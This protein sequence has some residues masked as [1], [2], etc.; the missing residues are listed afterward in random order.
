MYAIEALLE[1]FLTPVQPAEEYPQPSMPDACAEVL[2]SDGRYLVL[3][4]GRGAG[5]SWSVARQLLWEGT[6]FPIRV[7]C[8]REF[9]KSI[10]DSVH[11]LLSDMIEELGY[12]AH[13]RVLEHEIRG[14]NGTVFWFAGLHHNVKNIKSKEGIDV[15]WIEEA[16]T[17]SADSL[18]K[19]LPT[20]RKVGSRIILTFNP[21]QETDAVYLMFVED[22]TN[23]QWELPP[24]TVRKK[25]GWQDNPYISQEL[26]DLKDFAY[27]VD[28]VAAEH[29]WGGKCRTE[30]E[31]QILRG[32]WSW[33]WFE[34]EPGWRGPYYGLDFG[35]SQDPL[36]AVELWIGPGVAPD[37]QRLYARREA[38]KVGVDIDEAPDY[39]IGCIPGLAKHTVR[40]DSARPDNISYLKRFGLPYIEG[41]EKGDKSVEDGIAYLRGFE[42]IIVHKECPN[43]KEECRLY[44]F[45]VEA[46]TKKVLREPVDAHNHL[47]DSARYALE[48]LIKYVGPPMA[49]SAAA[50][51]AQARRTER[52]ARIRTARKNGVLPPDSRRNGR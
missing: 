27:R 10:K 23:P 29:V 30:T 35:F 6:R 18:E 16:E 32:R 4:G 1:G 28:A 9:Q 12:Q 24:S 17:T 2:H 37:M 13:Y 52:D 40:A 49:F 51:R 41:A 36:A 33:E 8:A 38:Y 3:Y 43:F 21:D 45:K 14:N 31:A 48:P 44:S 26:L 22:P 19:V 5:R 39:L 46:D 47:I 15:L 7:L 42:W 20:I 11:Q 50:L 25:V 34:V